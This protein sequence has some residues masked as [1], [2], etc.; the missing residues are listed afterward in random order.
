LGSIRRQGVDLHQRVAPGL[1]IV[2]TIVAEHDGYVTADS[3][4][5]QRETAFTRHPVAAGDRPPPR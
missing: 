3:S 2:R 1:T 5:P 4:G